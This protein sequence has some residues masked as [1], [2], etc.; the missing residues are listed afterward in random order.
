MAAPPA[1]VVAGAGPG[2][3]VPT[4]AQILAGMNVQNAAINA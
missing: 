1:A 4:L 2:I 3:N